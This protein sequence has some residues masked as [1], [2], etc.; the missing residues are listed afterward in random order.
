[1]GTKSNYGMGLGLGVREREI[2]SS[3][4]NNTS[5]N[6]TKVFINQISRIWQKLNP[7]AFYE[8]NSC[9]N[10]NTIDTRCHRHFTNYEL[11]LNEYV[12]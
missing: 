11:R 1:M 12:L 2:V 9:T 5:P 8:V 10:V 3:S 7:K 4:N 6:V